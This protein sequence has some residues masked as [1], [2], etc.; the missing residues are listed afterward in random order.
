MRLRRHRDDAV[1]TVDEASFRQIVADADRPV[2]VDFYARWCGPC[3]AL[4]PRI[5]ELAERHDA[6]VVKVNVDQE[7]D[8]AAQFDVRMIPTVIRFD[9][10]NESRRV[11]GYAALRELEAELG[12]V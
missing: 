12:L 4:A 3:R 9:E 2:I 11:V 8:L 6:T 5:V 1:A 10:G 7:R